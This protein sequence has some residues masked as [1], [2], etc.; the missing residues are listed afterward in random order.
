MSSARFCVLVPVKRPAVAKSRLA[1]VGDQARRDLVAA[2]AAD[3]V[4]A[5]LECPLVGTVLAVTDDAG[6]A[7]A[8][9]GLGAHVLPDGAGDDLNASLVQAAAEAARRWPDLGVAA[10]CADLPALR[11]ADLS[12]AL[13]AAAR[14]G[15]VFVPDADGRGTTLV[16]SDSAAGFTPR[17]GPGS[18]AAHLAAGL[19][20]LADLPVPSLRRDVDTPVD[21]DAARE[22]GLGPR[23]TLVTTGHRL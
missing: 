9:S 7:D 6:L 12:A 11:P 10:L 14:A 18:R 2:F 21:L 22:L 16:A 4:T 1:A 8:L 23:T 20:E 19:H 15:R 5:A 17:F 3:T 13:T